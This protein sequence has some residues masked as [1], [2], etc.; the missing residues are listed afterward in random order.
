[1]ASDDWNC[2]KADERI[3]TVEYALQWAFI[4]ECARLELPDRRAPEDRYPSVGTEYRLLERMRLGNVRIDT[5]PGRSSPHFDAEQ[6]A[7]AVSQMPK[8]LGG[9]GMA[10]F[11]QDMARSGR[12]PDWMPGAVPRIEPVAWQRNNQYGRAAKTEILRVYYREK[13]VPHPKNPARFV[14]RRVKVTEE[15][16]PCVWSPSIQEIDS[17]RQTYARWIDA[18][19][20]VSDSLREL[21]F[22]DIILLDGLPDPAPWLRDHPATS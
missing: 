21:T 10:I 15:Y 1:M 17:A 16:C 20:W 4:N 7:D 13:K 8:D 3:F 18:L 9:V 14:T 19:E 6:I 22:D 11:V 2:T 12:R 5:S